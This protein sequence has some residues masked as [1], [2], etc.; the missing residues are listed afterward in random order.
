MN[1]RFVLPE[2]SAQEA[3][4]KRPKQPFIRKQAS[5]CNP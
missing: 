1:R 2:I 4:K 5:A 3:P